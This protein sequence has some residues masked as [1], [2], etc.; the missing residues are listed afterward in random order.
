MY[1]HPS[2]RLGQHFLVDPRVAGRIVE[3]LDVSAEGVVLEIGPGRGILTGPLLRLGLPLVAVER[4]ERLA[5][6]LSDRYRDR[7]NVRI[8]CDDILNFDIPSLARGGS[9][10]SVSVIGNIPF[11]ITS[12]LLVCLIGHRDILGE[13]ILMIQKEVADRLLAP[14]GGRLYGRLTVLLN[15]YGTIE[16]L[17]HVGRGSFFPAPKVDATVVKIILNGP[18]PGR[19]ARDEVFFLRLVRILFGWRRKQVQKILRTHPDIGL[20]EQ[21]LSLLAERVDFPL[22]LRPERLSVP[23]LLLLADG[24][25]AVRGR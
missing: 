3:A 23:R 7:V 11:H 17:F 15:Y 13:V 18:C 22:S 5:R 20:D 4:D 12:P 21:E 2:K 9:R 19:I 10:G 14:P 25:L 24:I 6:V 1:P 8:V 16:P